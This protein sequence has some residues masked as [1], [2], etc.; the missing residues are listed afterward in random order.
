MAI[1]SDTKARNIK[2]DDPQLAD[3][4]VTGLVLI[5]SRT[6]GRGKWVLRFVSPATGKR[7]NAGLGCVDLHA[8]QMMAAA[9]VT[10]EAKRSASLS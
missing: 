5:P 4:G 10:K 2:P 8:S 3:G 6:K 9:R 7:R 1:L